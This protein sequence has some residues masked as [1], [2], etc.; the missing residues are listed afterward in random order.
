MGQSNFAPAAHLINQIPLYQLF[1]ASKKIGNNP[2]KSRKKN[3]QLRGK[4]GKS[5]AAG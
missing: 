2:K 5:V 3:P 4:L 1:Y